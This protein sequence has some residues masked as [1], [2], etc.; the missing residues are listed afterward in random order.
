MK[1]GSLLK[2]L[3]SVNFNSPKTGGLKFNFESSWHFQRVGLPVL[4]RLG[5]SK[6]SKIQAQY[7]SVKLT[8]LFYA[9]IPIYSPGVERKLFWFQ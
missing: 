6:S 3:L 1:T 9:S 7:C 2:P 5:V 8:A 4:S